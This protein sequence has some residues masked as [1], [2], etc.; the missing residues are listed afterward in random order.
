MSPRAGLDGRGKSR[1]HRD[2]IPRES[3]HVYSDCAVSA[4]NNDLM[5]IFVE[6]HTFL[7]R[8]ARLLTAGLS[9]VHISYTD[10]N[11]L[12]YVFY[13]IREFCRYAVV[14]SIYSNSFFLLTISSRNHLHLV[15]QFAFYL[16]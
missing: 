9:A 4:H 16:T 8:R 13:D 2:S 15:F 14:L 1:L 11:I 7:R 3:S 5:V 10:S 12:L 6:V